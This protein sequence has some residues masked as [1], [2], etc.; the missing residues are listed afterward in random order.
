MK[1]KKLLIVLFPLILGIAIYV[2]YRSRN[3]FYFKL[4]KSHDML[5]NIVLYMRKFAW[6]Y[7]LYFPLWAVYSLP[8]GLWLMSLGLALLIDRVFFKLH[9]FIFTLVYLVMISFEYIQ[10]FYGGHGTF[11]GTY[12]KM[13][14]IFFTFGY[15][16]AIIISVIINKKYMPKEN[17]KNSL[18]WK[19]EIIKSIKLII[20]FI[21]LAGLPTLI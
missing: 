12:D 8:D 19:K 10:K 11:I 1:R 17:F 7:R 6:K 16:L 14:I 21:I 2:A 20:L 15:I 4:I 5:H 13:D 9:F 18:T 3:L